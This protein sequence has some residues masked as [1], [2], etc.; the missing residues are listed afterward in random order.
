[1]KH[2]KLVNQVSAELN[3]SACSLTAEFFSTQK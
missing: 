2:G 1:M 3:Y